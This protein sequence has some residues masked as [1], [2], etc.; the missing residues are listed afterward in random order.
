MDHEW[1]SKETPLQRLEFEIDQVPITLFVPPD[2]PTHNKP[3]FVRRQNETV[4]TLN[5]EISY[6]YGAKREK[7]FSA[8]LIS[9]MAASYNGYGVVLL[10][11]QDY[12]SPHQDPKSLKSW[13]AINSSFNP[14][15]KYPKTPLAI[16]KTYAQAS[17]IAGAWLSHQ[18]LLSIPSQPRTLLQQVVE[19]LHDLAATGVYKRNNSYFYETTRFLNLEDAAHNICMKWLHDRNRMRW[20]E[21]YHNIRKTFYYQSYS[22]DETIF[23]QL[24]RNYWM[25]AV[26]DITCAVVSPNQEIGY[27]YIRSNADIFHHLHIDPGYKDL[28]ATDYTRRPFY[29]NMYLHGQVY[30]A[31]VNYAFDAR[32]GGI[33]EEEYHQKCA[34]DGIYMCWGPESFMG[35]P[36]I[37]SALARSDHSQFSDT[38]SSLLI[39]GT[40]GAA[41]DSRNPHRNRYAA[42]KIFIDRA[43]KLRRN[44]PQAVVQ[45]I[46]QWGGAKDDFALTL[47]E[48]KA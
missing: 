21:L 38:G 33:T 11:T 35:V 32:S 14:Q 46:Q 34:P 26:M 7:S 6:L 2:L 5:L 20:N 24:W 45:D 28:L 4:G 17:D 25:N 18:Q 41:Y 23:L 9:A 47:I 30:D 12:L 15:S 13:E 36:W 22:H 40:D 1:L 29:N 39:A 48:V 8:D 37:T 42:K 27:A 31:D 44:G 43:D 10:E 19:E 16:E 3:H